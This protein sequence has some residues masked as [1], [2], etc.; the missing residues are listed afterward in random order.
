MI[1]HLPS[2]QGQSRNNAAHALLTLQQRARDNAE[3]AAVLAKIV[4]RANGQ[5]SQS[6]PQR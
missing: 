1:I 4:A 6:Q 3:A 5:Q 2:L